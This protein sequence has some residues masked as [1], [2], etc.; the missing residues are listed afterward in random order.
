M[1]IYRRI[2][3]PLTMLIVHSNINLPEGSYLGVS[4][5]CFINSQPTHHPRHHH[6]TQHDILDVGEDL[7]QIDQLFLGYKVTHGNLGRSS[8][9]GTH[10]LGNL[11]G[12]SW[13]FM[14]CMVV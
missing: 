13:D 6:G 1:A 3:Y 4:Q 7:G 10:P 11:Y 5:H 2:T 9:L 12:I 14:G 8:N